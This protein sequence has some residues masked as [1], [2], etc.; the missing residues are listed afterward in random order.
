[1]NYKKEEYKDPYTHNCEY[2]K[3]TF[4]TYP[5][6]LDWVYKINQ[7]NYATRWFCSW[8]CQMKYEKENN[9][10]YRVCH[11]TTYAK[12]HKRGLER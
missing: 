7:Q 1:M 5:A 10:K 8:S 11:R 6:I 3:E 2:C 9:I 4:N 12:V